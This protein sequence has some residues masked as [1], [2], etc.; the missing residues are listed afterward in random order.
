MLY[1]EPTLVDASTWSARPSTTPARPTRRCA[2]GSPRCTRSLRTP[3]TRWRPRAGWRWCASGSR[4][5][6]R[7]CR[8]GRVRR[9]RP[10][11]RRLRDLL[12]ARVVEG[13]G[14]AE[15]ARLLGAHPTHLV[16]AFGR[17]FGIAPHR[18]LT[19]RRVDRARRL[20][21]AGERP[22]DAAVAVG[23]HDQSHLTRHF[24]RLL[25]TTPAAYARS[26]S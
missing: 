20:L 10:L 11:A 21:L 5:I 16:R 15:A 2:T 19:G 18:Y 7:T 9:D 26:A 25:G 4:R 23:F 6:C 14:L 13:V 22:A 1:L 24:R 12:D 3:A 8:A 17:E